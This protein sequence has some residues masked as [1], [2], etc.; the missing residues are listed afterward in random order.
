MA[1]ERSIDATAEQAVY[2]NLDATQEEILGAMDA[3]RTKLHLVRFD[4][5]AVKQLCVN[6][7]DL[8]I[9]G[10]I[11]YDEAAAITDLEEVFRAHSDI[12]TLDELQHF[13]GLKE[14]PD[15]AFRNNSQLISLYLPANVTKVGEKAF[16][17]CNKL[18]YLAILNPATTPVDAA[19]SAL[20]SGTTVFVPSAALEAYRADEFWS[21][22]QIQEYTGV[23]TVT[24]DTLS[25]TYGTN[26]ARLTFSVSGAPVNGTPELSTDINAATPVGDYDIFIE[27]GSI[28]IRGLQLQKGVYHVEPATLTVTAKSYTREIGEQNPTFEYTIKGFKNKETEAVLTALPVAECEATADSPWGDYPILF[29]GAAAP[30]Y[31]FD[32][33]AGTLTILPPVGIHD[34]TDAE[35][36]QPVFDLAGRRL[37]S[38]ALDHLPSGIYIIA[39]RR[40]LV[41]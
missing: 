36:R 2:D 29:S 23:P 10:E 38:N 22:Y 20:P 9:D 6:N 14:I 12:L 31:I 4:S 33:V 28:T 16:N 40:I 3:L 34:L 41:K 26:N 17:S 18:K 11:S 24:P 1:A 19:A 39:G 27:A 7:W 25:R 8:D 30:N 5:E 35:R 21:R 37:N 15:N 13:T 32:Y